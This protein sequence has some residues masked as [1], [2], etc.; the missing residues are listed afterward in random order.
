MKAHRHHD[1][2]RGLIPSLDIYEEVKNGTKDWKPHVKNEMK[3]VII[4]YE[5]FVRLMALDKGEEK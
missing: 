3:E 5:L 4:P 1:G 2:W